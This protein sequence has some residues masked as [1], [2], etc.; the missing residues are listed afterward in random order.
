MR[1]AHALRR[2]LAREV[3]NQEIPRKPPKR[4]TQMRGPARDWKYRAWIRSLPC[5]ACDT[6]TN[7]EAAHTGPHAVNQKASD[8][9][10]I[11]LCL[12]HH[13]TGDEALDKIGRAAFERRFNRDIAALVKR[14]NRIWF[15][16][17]KLEA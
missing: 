2:W 8:Y 16:S 13:R 7:V 10:C 5:A 17:M 3:L 1:S 9:T 12:Q 6:A 11:P 4:T 14:L 15:E